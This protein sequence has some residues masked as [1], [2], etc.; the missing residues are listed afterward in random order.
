MPTAIPIAIAQGA[1]ERLGLLE[2]KL[3]SASPSSRD[4]RLGALRGDPDVGRVHVAAGAEGGRLKPVAEV[5]R[6]LLGADRDDR[7]PR[8]L[9]PLQDLGLRLCDRLDSPVQLEMD[10]A[11]VGDGRDVGLGDLAQLGDLALTPH[12]HLHHQDLGLE[13]G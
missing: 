13:R 6:Q 8:P 11:A 3:N 10:V 1:L 5:R 2:G 7:L 9:Q 4:E 12:R